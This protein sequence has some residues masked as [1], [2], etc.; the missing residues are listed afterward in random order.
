MKGLLNNKRILI[1]REAT[2]AGDFAS[3]I[4]PYQGV[5]I[6]APLL[7]IDTYYGE[8]NEL[9]LQSLNQYDWVF[10]TSV[11]G[12]KHFFKQLTN[13]NLLKGCRIAVVG[14]KTEAELKNYGFS[15]DFMPSTYNAD[16]MAAEFI[17][18]FQIVKKVLFV[19]GNLSRSVLLHEFTHAKIHYSKLTVYETNV[20]YDI[21]E[22][23][24][25]LLNE[26]IDFITFM[27]P[28]TIHAFVE[29]IDNEDL[30]DDMRSKKCFCIGTTT[31]QAAIKHQFE[32]TYIP[33]VFTTEG[34]IQKMIDI[35]SMEENQK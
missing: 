18:S 31:E 26:K 9:I 25:K 13:W 5:P 29:L 24:N 23:L 19:R 14:D 11:N 30:L 1:T 8:N 32:K 15:A 4:K 16:T 6:I 34:I 28:S 2:Q 20:N 3:K 33:N 21:K 12:V 17:A 7:K 22:K 10:F 35:V 27:S